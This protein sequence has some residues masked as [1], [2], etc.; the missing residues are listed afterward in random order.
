MPV[1]KADSL[2]CKDDGKENL[3]SLYRHEDI[4]NKAHRT[5][6][7]LDQSWTLDV[8]KLA[9]PVIAPVLDLFQ[10][11]N[12]NKASP[13]VP[14][15]LIKRFNRLPQ[16]RDLLDL[17]PCL[18]HYRK[19][20]YFYI[21]SLLSPLNLFDVIFT[22]LQLWHHTLKIIVQ[23]I[24]ER[25]P[26]NVAYLQRRNIRLKLVLEL[27]SFVDVLGCQT[28]SQLCQFSLCL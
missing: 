24:H 16:R 27:N 10:V 5:R 25:L 19:L 7:L 8:G 21:Q 1:L 20:G 14:M 26:P 2:E 15:I 13:P 23:I 18:S 3:Y 22:L 6:I 4:V 11:Q 28:Y 17:V 9:C 12:W